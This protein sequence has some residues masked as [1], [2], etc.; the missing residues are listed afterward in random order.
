MYFLMSGTQPFYWD[1][2]MDRLDVQ[3][4]TLNHNPKP[5]A[6]LVRASQAFSD[7]VEKAMK[8]IQFERHRTPDIFVEQLEA[9]CSLISDRN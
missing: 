4:A 7:F 2:N 5:L 9:L 1:P 6:E 8:K 3:L